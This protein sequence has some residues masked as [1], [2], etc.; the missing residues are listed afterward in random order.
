MSGEQRASYTRPAEPFP[1]AD[2]LP[3]NEITPDV[4]WRSMV[5]GFRAVHED[6]ERSR[7]ELQDHVHTEIT[8]VRKDLTVLHERVGIVDQR[9]LGAKAKSAAG[10]TG[11]VTLALTIAAQIASMYRPGLVGPI[12]AIAQMLTGA[13]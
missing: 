5:E 10:W 6:I 4:L 9:T 8:L 3:R 13:Q 2:D 1:V 12:Q 7:R 11:V